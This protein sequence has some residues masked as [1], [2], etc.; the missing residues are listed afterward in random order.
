MGRESSKAQ[1]DCKRRTK[2][3][4]NG[5]IGQR[6]TVDGRGWQNLNLKCA[7]A[8]YACYI[9]LCI[10]VLTASGTPEEELV[11]I[12]EREV[13]SK[14]S[15]SKSRR[16]ERMRA[17]AKPWGWWRGWD[18]RGFSLDCSLREFKSSSQAFEVA[19]ASGA[20]DVAIS[21]AIPPHRR[22]FDRRW[23]CRGGLDAASRLFDG[24]I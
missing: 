1:Q 17:C 2:A 7:T 9:L 13:S 10:L 16:S 11:G 4:S 22:C 20:A 18:M 3:Q 19:D 5:G 6:T 15:S 12:F 8:T 24:G 23:R 21:S 14:V